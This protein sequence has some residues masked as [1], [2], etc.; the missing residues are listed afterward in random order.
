M[1]HENIT[2]NKYD[3]NNPNRRIAAFGRS[4]AIWKYVRPEVFAPALPYAAALT[5]THP[6]VAAGVRHHSVFNKNAITPFIRVLATADSGI[7]L[8]SDRRYEVDRVASKLYKFHQTVQGAHDS[9]DGQDWNG[10]TYGANMA[11]LQTFVGTTLYDTFVKTHNR[12][13]GELSDDNKHDLWM[14]MMDFM[15]TIGIPRSEMPSSAIEA[16][17]YI[18]NFIE[19]G[20]AGSTKTSY[21]V[22]R[23][24]VNVPMLDGTPITPAARVVT[25]LS[26]SLF[27]P[28]LQETFDIVPTNREQKLIKA[29][30]FAIN[31]FIKTTP[32]ILRLEIIPGYL[33]GR[34]VV[35]PVLGK[36]ASALHR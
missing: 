2:W 1:N 17:E 3:D 5:T 34:R 23:E 35:A 15:E 22:T 26:K 12:W 36:I 33:A 24:V 10:K 14:D 31:S 11:E 13:I 32:D 27:D 21:D 20:L 30:D 8:V 4:S 29:A 6:G 9:I 28:R 25:A 16:D 19:S 18:E 7:Q